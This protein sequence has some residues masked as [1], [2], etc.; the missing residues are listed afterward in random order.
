MIK[1]C[2][3]GKTVRMNFARYDEIFDMPD[4]VEIQKGSYQWFLEKGLREVLRDVSPI[5]DYSGNYSIEFVDYYL[6]SE[7]PKYPEEESKERDV[8][9]AAPLRVKVRLYNKQSGEVIERDIF[10]GDFPLM[11]KKGTFIINGAERVIVSQIVRSPGAYYSVEIDKTGRHIYSA[12]VIPYCGAWIEYETDTNEQFSVRIDKN[13]KIPITVLIRALGIGADE[14]IIKY[15]GEDSRLIATMENDDMVKRAA[16]KNETPEN[17]ALKEIFSRIRPGEPPI[18]ESAQQLINNMFFDPKRYDLAAVGRF[19]FNKKLSLSARLT[20]HTISRPLVNSYTGELLYDSDTVMSEEMAIKVEDCGINEAWIYADNDSEVKIFGNGMAHPLGLVGDDLSDIGLKPTDKV[21]IGLL[22]E[23]YERYG[24]DMSEFKKAVALRISELM[25]KHI[26]KD[27]IF[28]SINYFVNLSRGV[29]NI[30]DIDHLGNRRLRSVGELLQ[31]QMRI[32]FARM[33]KNVRERM[34]VLDSETITPESLINIRPVVTSIREFFGSSPLSQFM[35]Q[36][37]PLAELTHKRRI[38]ALGPGGLSRDRASFEVRDVHYTHYGRMCPIE[39][40]E[41]PNIGLISYLATYARVN[42]YGFIMTPYRRVDKETGIVTKEVHYLTAEEEERYILVQANEPLTPEH[43]FVNDRVT[44]RRKGD[45]VEVAKTEVDY[46]DVSPE[47]VVSVAT[48]MIPFLENDDN[49]RA[50]MGSNMQKQAV[51]LMVTE[52]PIV[53]TG[54]E[55]KAALDSGVVVI[56]KEAG[57]VVSVTANDIT[58]RNDEGRKTVYHLIKFKR[59]N[60]GTCINQRP[61]VVIG[62]YVEAGQVIADGPATSQGEISLG[63]NVLIGFM[64]WEGYNFEDAVLLNENLVRDDIYTSIHIEEYSH[65]ARDTKLGPEEITREIP[66]VGEDALK[67]LSHEG[68]IRM[69]TEV[70]AGDILVGKV[71]PKGETELTAEERLLRAIFGEKAREVRDTSLRLPHGES[72]IVVDIKVFSRENGDELSPGVNKE[73]KVYVA[74]KRKISVGDKMAGRH[75][76]KGV[77]SRILPQEDMPFLADGTPL[78]IVLNPMGVP[79]RMNIGQV[80][81]VHLGYAAKKLG[82]K[83]MS[84]VFDGANEHDITKCMLEAGIPANGKQILYDGRTG[85]PFDNPVTVGIMYY[86]KLHHLVDDKI[87]ARSTGPYS[88]VTQQPLGGKA[89]FGGQRFGEMEVWALEAYG[90]AYTLQEILTVKSDDVNGRTK[91]FEAI[92]KGQNVPT[93]GVPESFKVLVKEL[94]SLS[95]DVRVLDREG[96][97]ITLSSLADEEMANIP[98]YIESSRDGAQDDSAEADYAD[99]ENELAEAMGAKASAPVSAPDGFDE[100]DER[101]VDDNIASDDY[102]DE[103]R[104][105]SDD[106]PLEVYEDNSSDDTDDSYEDNSDYGDEN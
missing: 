94:Q 45:I 40:P 60:Q 14:E 2:M 66:N 43:T 9:Y 69:G 91:T 37:N 33:D 27:D 105:D 100:V 47:M 11:T 18:V 68:I 52:Q 46:M 70:R 78:D 62:D 87:H 80:L 17:E 64:T 51:P 88:L 48:A 57:T 29:G 95:L 63:K 99:R 58:I 82:W 6:D 93:P 84:P 20:G 24:S 42:E 104:S 36:N 12:Q 4:L 19:K 1:P 8:N 26:T 76:N 15:F 34:M 35:D 31:N 39:T 23:L 86:L 25:P 103:S 32:G 3:F 59:S 106:E 97:E 38:S 71:T 90:A 28:A 61:I 83:V 7:N 75:G 22:L 73:V 81:E 101:F 55:Y 49:S 54:V 10:M 98:N 44:V 96:Y 56:A 72:G 53:G 89:Q 92:V 102:E 16:E 13:R 67:D 21:K 77:V 41:G 74:Q 85:E 65:E 79:S 30:D 5:T 50:L